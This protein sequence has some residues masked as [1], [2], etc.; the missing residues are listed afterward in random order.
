MVSWHGILF[1]QLEKFIS[2]FEQLW[3]RVRR[4]AYSNR[5]I[6]ETIFIF[7]YSIEQIF[8]V[9]FAFKIKNIVELGLIVSIFAIIVLTT[10]AMHKLVMESRI[11]MLEKEIEEVTVKK[12]I[13]EGNTKIIFDKYKELID[14]TKKLK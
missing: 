12:D 2:N 1:H 9:W 6:F 8:L 3:N 7:L 5:T 13:I 4:L 11:K 14:S 10:F